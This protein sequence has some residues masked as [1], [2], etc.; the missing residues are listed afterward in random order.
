MKSPLLLALALT[1]AV[2]A[3]A[4]STDD[5]FSASLTDLSNRVLQLRRSALKSAK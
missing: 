5:A 4:A 3:A 1:L 2:P